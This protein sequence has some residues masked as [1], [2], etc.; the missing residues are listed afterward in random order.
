[1]YSNNCSETMKLFVYCFL[2]KYLKT[3]K[4][5]QGDGSIIKIKNCRLKLVY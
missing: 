2:Y 5:K 1:M 4:M 3:A